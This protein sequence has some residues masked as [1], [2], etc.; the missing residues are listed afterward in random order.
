MNKFYCLLLLLTYSASV[1]AATV[2]KWVDDDG[3]THYSEK[4]NANQKSKP[5]ELEYPSQPTFHEVYPDPAS[6][7]QIEQQANELEQAR[8]AREK[9]A[10]EKKQKLLN[11]IEAKKFATLIAEFGGGWVSGAELEPQCRANYDKSC[12][13]L[14]NWKA[15][16]YAQCEK[17]RVS[18]QDCN[19]DLYLAEN[20]KPLTIQQQRLQ[21][22]QNRAWFRKYRHFNPK[23]HHDK[24]SRDKWHRNDKTRQSEH[25]PII[26]KDN[27]R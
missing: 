24:K 8:L 19:N 2:Y 22:I 3:V 21:G 5:I 7:N 12:D 25:P 27:R 26:K 1:T 10:R 11:D 18:H 4:Q 13:E 16:A 14:L 9:E 17:D 20:Y 15:I 6:A 23:R